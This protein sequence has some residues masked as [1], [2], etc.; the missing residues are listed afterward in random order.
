MGDLTKKNQ[1]SDK[2]FRLTLNN[3]LFNKL[4]LDVPAFTEIWFLTMGY[5]TTKQ[6][7]NSNPNSEQA[8]AI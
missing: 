2:S 3:I 5:E 1:I 6:L 4:L 8:D 7:I